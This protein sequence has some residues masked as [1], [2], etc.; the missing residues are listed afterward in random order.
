VVLTKA[1]KFM[2]FFE[3]LKKRRSIR[4]FKPD[5]IPEDKLQ[6]IYE[7]INSAPSAGDLQA[8]EV[9]WKNLNK[10]KMKIKLSR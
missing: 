3:V 2:D 4:K 6:L 10:Q 9:F 5:A 7:A 1:N 8:Y